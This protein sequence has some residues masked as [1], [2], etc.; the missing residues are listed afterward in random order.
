MDSEYEKIIKE[1]LPIMEKCK[2]YMEVRISKKTNN[3]YCCLVADLGYCEKILSFNRN[4]IA[5][6]L[7]VPVS[8]LADMKPNTKLSCGFITE[9]PK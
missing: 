7:G 6:C 4:D 5:E 1:F 2:L 8:V 3:P 9:L